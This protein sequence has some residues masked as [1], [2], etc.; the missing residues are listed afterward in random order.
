MLTELVGGLDPSLSNFGMSKGYL[1]DGHIVIEDIKLVTTKEDKTIKYKN[2]RDLLRA[3]KLLE[4]IK[5]FFID[6]DT[7]YTEIPVGSQ[8]ARA[9][10]SYGICIGVLAS[11]GKKI[12]RVSAKD[13]KL[14]ATGN[15]E[16]SKED[17]IAW[18]N[19]VYP[20]LPWLT[21]RLKDNSV[22]TKA[23]EHVADSIA[24]IHAGINNAKINSN[25]STP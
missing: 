15:P 17:I 14:I 2:E 8:S 21:R 7:I 22:L 18:A 20:N 1:H 16:A 23:N 5:T 24:A 19:N 3:V 9:M 6:V 25:I 12:V 13:V 11:L 10:A 4:A